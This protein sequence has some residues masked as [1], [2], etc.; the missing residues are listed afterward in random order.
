MEGKIEIIH[1]KRRVCHPELQVFLTQTIVNAKG[2]TNARVLKEIMDIYMLELFPDAA[3]FD[4]H[5]VIFKLD[6]GSGRLNILVL[7]ELRCKGVYLFPGVQN[8]AHATQGSPHDQPRQ[9]DATC[10]SIL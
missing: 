9:T 10:W 6:G 3:D 4:D 7:A 1:C 5:R 8:T 2:G